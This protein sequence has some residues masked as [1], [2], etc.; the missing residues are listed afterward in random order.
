MT[1]PSDFPPFPR[2]TKREADDGLDALEAPQGGAVLSAPADFFGQPSVVISPEAH[3]PPPP[4]DPRHKKAAQEPTL[5][6]RDRRKVASL[7]AELTREA[8]RS[9]T[10]RYKSALFWACAGLGAFSLGGGLVALLGHGLTPA[11]A[12]VPAPVAQPTPFAQG[13]AFAQ[14]AQG[15]QGPQGTTAAPVHPVV[16]AAAV[17]QAA[18]A[19]H[20]A[21]SALEPV[22]SPSPAASS[23]AA[24]EQ[25]PSSPAAVEPS[26]RVVP[27]VVSLED[28][29]AE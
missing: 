17:M 4:S 3:L 23:E 9:A 10:Q 7:R 18:S 14:G 20:A 27:R 11:S 12:S 25:A 28:L 24:V 21:D 6:I 29:P 26:V 5:V 19:A 22:P 16:Q 1:A 2:A 13:A 8:S 15:T